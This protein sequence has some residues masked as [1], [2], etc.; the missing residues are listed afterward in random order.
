MGGDL[1]PKK[2]MSFMGFW[3]KKQKNTPREQQRATGCG[4]IQRER[5]TEER[6]RWREDRNKEE[7]YSLPLEM[8]WPR[9]RAEEREFLS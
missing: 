9:G 1:G 4:E 6:Q 5:K 8:A 7:I 2:S 3:L